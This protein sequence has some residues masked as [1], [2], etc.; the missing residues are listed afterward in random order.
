[1]FSLRMHASYAG[2]TQIRYEGLS[3]LNY[4]VKQPS[5]PGVYKRKPTSYGYF[6][7]TAQENIPQIV[8]KCLDPREWEE[9]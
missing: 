8:Y 2:S 6:L 4:L 3:Q 9:C 1:M 7:A 5:T